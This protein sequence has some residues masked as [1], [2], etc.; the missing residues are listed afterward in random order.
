M[1][2]HLDEHLLFW[3]PTISVILSLHCTLFGFLDENKI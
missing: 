3:Q 1:G 2:G